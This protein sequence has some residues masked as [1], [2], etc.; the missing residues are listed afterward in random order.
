MPVHQHH[1][2]HTQFSVSHFQVGNG[3]ELG[4]HLGLDYLNL[5]YEGRARIYKIER[6]VQAKPGWSSAAVPSG[7]PVPGWLCTDGRRKTVTRACW[8]ETSQQALPQQQ[9]PA[10]EPPKAKLSLL[11][12]PAVHILPSVLLLPLGTPVLEAKRHIIL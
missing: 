3:T 10:A 2:T 7:G 6:V 1:T 12:P 8:E 9:T 11:L 5:H 4:V